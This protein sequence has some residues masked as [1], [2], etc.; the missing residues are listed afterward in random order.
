MI[1]EAEGRPINFTDAIVI[2]VKVTDA[3]E[4]NEIQCGII[5]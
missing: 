3:A 1:V 5:V 2:C 4:I